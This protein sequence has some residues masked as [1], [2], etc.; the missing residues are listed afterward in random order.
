MFVVCLSFCRWCGFRKWTGDLDP[1]R[2][3][4]V[5]FGAVEHGDAPPVRTHD[6]FVAAARANALHKRQYLMKEKRSDPPFKKDS[7]YKTSGVKEFSPLCCYPMFNIVWDVLM[8]FMHM[9]PVI[10]RDHIVPL[11]RGKRYPKEPK[12]RDTWTPAQNRALKD[13]WKAVLKDMHTW[14]LHKVTHI[15]ML[16]TYVK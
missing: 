14:V 7:P 3:N 2:Y 13:E 10:L 15:N 11:M 5:D 4:A 8:C 9:V 12:A 6:G 1:S 16:L